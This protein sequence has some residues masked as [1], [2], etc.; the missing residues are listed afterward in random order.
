MDEFKKYFQDHRAELWEEMKK[1]V[2]PRPVVPFYLRWAAAAC[3]GMLDLQ[4][5]Q[6]RSQSISTSS[7]TSLKT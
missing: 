5:E 6:I 2:H 4:L 7:K 1:I 3:A